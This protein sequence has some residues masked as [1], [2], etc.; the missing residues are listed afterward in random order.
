MKVSILGCGWF[1]LA[2]GRSL[3]SQGITV[4]GS[5]TTAK[6]LEQLSLHGLQPYLVNIQPGDTLYDPDFFACDLLWIAIPP[7][8]RGGEGSAFAEK[9]ESIVHIAAAHGVRHVLY[10]SS[11]KVYGE[12]GTIVNELTVPQPN[13]KAGLVL[14]AAEELLRRQQDRFASVTILRFAGLIGP[15]RDPGG[16]LAGKTEVTNGDAP[17]NLIHLDDCVGIANRIMQ[18]QAFGNVFNACCPHHPARS[19]FYTLA[20]AA[21]DLQAPAFIAKKNRWKIVDSLYVQPTLGYD[22]IVDNWDQWFTHNNPATAAL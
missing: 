17:V 7:K 2:L 22:F 16:F 14:L 19:H 21:A 20:A 11:S 4:K 15:G 13:S 18:Q 3:I 12:P 10:T 9:L 8:T 5:T 6:K 1:G